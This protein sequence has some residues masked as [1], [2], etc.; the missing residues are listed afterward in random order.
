M[1]F[2]CPDHKIGIEL[3]GAIHEI[4]KDYDAARDKLV[5]D[6]GTKIIRLKN[7]EVLDKTNEVI[8]KIADNLMLNNTEQKVRK[9]VLPLHEY[10]EGDRG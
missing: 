6:L 7:R 1:D 5:S 9:N 2:Y 8:K 3:D 10:G 4:T